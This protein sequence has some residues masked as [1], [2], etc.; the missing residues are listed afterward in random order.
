MW[1]QKLFLRL[2]VFVLTYDN[3]LARLV[4]MKMTACEILIPVTSDTT[5]QPWPADKLAAWE[6]SLA[7]RFGGFT[8]RGIVRG[9]WLDEKGL[10]VSDESYCYLV[11]VETSKIDDLRAFAR[12]ACGEFE[13]RCIFFQV[14][15]GAELLYP[16]E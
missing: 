5:S 13:Q 11:A 16:E 4:L 8:L 1:R 15:G 10:L 3:T 14:L 2:V 12:A 6:A 7:K 9:A